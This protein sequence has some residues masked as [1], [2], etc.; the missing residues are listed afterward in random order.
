MIRSDVTVTLV[1]FGLDTLAHGVPGRLVGDLLP[2]PK[3]LPVTRHADPFPIRDLVLSDEP[4]VKVDDDVVSG[5]EAVRKSECGCVAVV[6]EERKLCGTFGILGCAEAVL[7]GYLSDLGGARMIPRSLDAHLLA[8]GEITGR[9]IA[10]FADRRSI[11]IETDSSFIH[12][13]SLFVKHQVAIVPVVEFGELAGVISQR[14]FL[15]CVI[16]QTNAQ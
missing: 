12:L 7:P 14:C 16:G 6:N 8:R 11:S 2:Y 1:L 15:E 5:I 4:I 13:A 9:R 3:S 10:D